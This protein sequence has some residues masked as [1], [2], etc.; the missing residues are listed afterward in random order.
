[1]VAAQP[2]GPEPWVAT[3]YE[4]DGAAAQGFLESVLLDGGG[5]RWGLR[6]GPQFQPYWLGSSE[7]ALAGPGMRPGPVA[8]GPVRAADRPP[9]RSLVAAVLTLAVALLVLALLMGV[10]F[11]CQPRPKDPPNP[12]PEP[13]PTFQSPSVAPPTP[14][15]PP[16]PTPSPSVSPSGGGGDDGAPI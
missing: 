8:S 15:R 1:V 10:L 11:A 5:R 12:P 4:A 3:E 6:R 13:L 7:A 2:D 16:N 9:E 14:Q